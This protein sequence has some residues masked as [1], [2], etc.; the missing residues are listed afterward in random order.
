MKKSHIHLKS[1]G[2]KYYLNKIM[3]VVNLSLN[4]KCQSVSAR[5]SNS[6]SYFKKW[7]FPH[8]SKNLQTKPLQMYY[9]LSS[10]RLVDIK[11]TKFYVEKVLSCQQ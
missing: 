7:K 3:L 1:P 9:S 10:E 11:I 5:I 4:V 8:S 2:N 6:N